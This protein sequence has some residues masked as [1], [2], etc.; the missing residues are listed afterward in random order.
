M[1]TGSDY[2]RDEARRLGN[3]V[4][5]AVLW[6][7]KR[8]ADQSADGNAAGADQR[9]TLVQLDY[10]ADIRARTGRDV[11]RK[12][13]ILPVRHEPA[14]GLF[15]GDMQDVTVTWALRIAYH[16]GGGDAYGGDIFQIHAVAVQDA[17]AVRQRLEHPAN[18]GAGTGTGVTA[19]RT[20]LVDWRGT[21]YEYDPEAKRLFSETTLTSRLRVDLEVA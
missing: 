4:S 19:G 1:P 14:G 15:S 10:T 21:T 7:E 9:A 16:I 3:L 20:A 18:F 11:H 13:Q 12:F 8:L 2:I 6:T 5:G 17:E